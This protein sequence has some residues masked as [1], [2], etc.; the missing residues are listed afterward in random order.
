MK[1][2]ILWLGLC[3]A[4]GPHIYAQR[5]V[6]ELRTTAQALTSQSVARPTLQTFKNAPN[7]VSA[8]LSQRV[9]HTYQQANRLEQA[10]VTHPLL[11]ILYRPQAATRL[12]HKLDIELR[13]N[14]YPQLK[15]ILH[16]NRQLTHYFLSQN[17]RQIIKNIPY[18]KARILNMQ[19]HIERL[20]A[21]Q[22]ISPY[23]AKY[24]LDVVVNAIPTSTDYLL[25]GEVHNVPEIHQQMAR[26]IPKLRSKFKYRKII[27]LTEFLPELI[28]A[29]LL[30]QE[31]PPALMHLWKTAIH[32]HIPVVGI[33]SLH[34]YVEDY[35]LWDW[36]SF[37]HMQPKTSI[38][39]TKEGIR[40]R[41]E[42]WKKQIALIRKRNPTALIVLH[43]GFGHLDNTEQYS[44]GTYLHEQGNTFTISFVPGLTFQDSADGARELLEFVNEDFP[45]DGLIP[46]S[47]FDFATQ[48][49][50]FQR[51]L[52]FGKED[53][54]ITGFDVQI[55]IP[56]NSPK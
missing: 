14:L 35:E 39:E 37:L 52:E 20:K 41:N 28:S 38:W 31:V 48:G 15:E 43:A 26:L 27:W 36:P 53:W 42:C 45:S 12:N 17:N 3:I 22:H 30:Q 10:L 44:L 32:R 50:F 25:L 13:D 51:I 29:D 16:T 56:I 5:N 8:Q 21:N 46:T 23:P 9:Q 33:E 1:K 24:D 40:L 11:S 47:F 6:K 18:E 7:K 2:I 55:K 54:K 19:Q 4:L 34:T 49:E